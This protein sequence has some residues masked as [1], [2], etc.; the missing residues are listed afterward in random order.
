MIMPMQER[1]NKQLEQICGN[2][3]NMRPLIV[4]NQEINPYKIVA[5]NSNSKSELDRPRRFS[6][7]ILKKDLNRQTID[8]LKKIVKK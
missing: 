4:D 6:Y 1:R 7:S 3:H 5:S 2:D 8:S